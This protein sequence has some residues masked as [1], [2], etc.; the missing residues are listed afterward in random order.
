MAQAVSRRPLAAEARVRARINLCGICGLQ[1][2]TG[3]DFSSSS[4]VFSC[5]YHSAVAVQSHIIWG[6]LVTAV[7]SRSLT[8]SKS[9]NQSV[10]HLQD[11]KTLQPRIDV[12]TSQS[13]R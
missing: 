4:S 7:Q 11:Y 9:I 10:N 6:K 2:G 12:G 8:L 3:T 13:V 1:S 5:Q